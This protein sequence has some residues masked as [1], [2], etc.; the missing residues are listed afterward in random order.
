MLFKNQYVG[1][2]DISG[3]YAFRNKIDGK[4]YVG[5]SKSVLTRKRQHEKCNA[6]NSRRFHYAMKKHT[7]NG[8]DWVVLEYCDKSILD[9]REAYWVSKLNSIHPYGYNLTSGGGAFQRHHPETRV[10]FSKNQIERVEQKTHIFV[11]KDFIRDQTQRQ[12]ELGKRGEHSSQRVE[13]RAKRNKT[14][15]ERMILNGKFFSHTPEEINRRRKIQVELYAK[16]LGKFQEPGFIERNRQL[17][18]EKLLTGNHHTQQEGWTEKSI[19]AHRHEMKALVV[20]IR[21][22]D[23]KTVERKFESLHEAER[24]LEADRSH[25]SAMCSGNSGVITVQCKIGKIIKGNFGVEAEWNIE[26]IKKLPNSYFTKKMTV[27]V[28]IKMHDGSVIVK[29][30][31]GQREACRQL[32]ASPRAFRGVLRKDKYKTTKCNL[33][34]ITQVVEVN[35][36]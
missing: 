5:Q 14:V 20:A 6:S 32:E 1:V 34:K 11:S 8:F 13:V 3:I 36:D 2:K 17:V 21:T 25:I 31:D 29:K 27:E 19:E 33:G 35:A 12:I 15:R 23:G 4:I 18:K 22:D 26:D 28:T 9:E 30:Y 16:G 24:Q 10:K 7:P